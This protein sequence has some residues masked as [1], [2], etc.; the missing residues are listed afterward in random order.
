[1]L[2][3]CAHW[4][5]GDT[6]GARQG[7]QALY[8]LR[9][10]NAGLTTCKG[11]GQATL[12]TKNGVQRARLAWAAQSPNKLRLELLAVSGHTLAALASDGAYLYLRDSTSDRFLQTRS[13]RASLEPLVQVPLYVPDLIA[14][15][16]G[17]VPRVTAERATL[18]DNPQKPGYILELSRWWG[19]TCQHIGLAEDGTTVEQ[20]TRF[21]ADGVPIYW[22]ELGQRHEEGEFSL[23]RRLT[24]KTKKGSQIDIRLDRFWPNTLIDGAAF[25]LER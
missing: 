13:S 3:G 22:V 15:L 8:N 2:G 10:V 17:R 5:Q 25:Q 6:P 1:L 20:V 16:F 12:T 18:M 4:P 7:L 9:T 19:K 21:G 23:P 24:V 14:Y 11:L